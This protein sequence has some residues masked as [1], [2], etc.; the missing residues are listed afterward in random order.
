MYLIIWKMLRRQKCRQKK[1]VRKEEVGAKEETV[2]E[3]AFVHLNMQWITQMFAYTDSCDSFCTIC[4]IF[5]D[6]FAALTSL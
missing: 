1:T 4:C 3:S 6:R 2:Y 5:S